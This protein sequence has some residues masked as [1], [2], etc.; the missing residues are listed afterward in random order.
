MIFFNNILVFKTLAIADGIGTDDTINFEKAQNSKAEHEKYY[1]DFFFLNFSFIVTN[2]I[3]F[4]SLY[5]T[6]P[7]PKKVTMLLQNEQYIILN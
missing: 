1:L 7:A 5:S 4:F 2:H 3:F 6:S